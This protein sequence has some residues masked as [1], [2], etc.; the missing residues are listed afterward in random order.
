[1][2]VVQY[3]SW[4]K[5]AKYENRSY[6]KSSDLFLSL[7]LVPASSWEWW[8]RQL[9]EFLS[10][11]Y[12]LCAEGVRILTTEREVKVVSCH[13]MAPVKARIQQQFPGALEDLLKEFFSSD[14]SLHTQLGTHKVLASLGARLKR[15]ELICGRGRELRCTL[16][17]C[18]FEP[19]VSSRDSFSQAIKSYG[20]TEQLVW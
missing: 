8:E 9:L 2:G 4:G 1:M 13:E 11:L 3:K 19:S 5:R 14:R 10:T 12:S 15:K 20:Q 6:W 18:G 16:Q 17:G 7:P